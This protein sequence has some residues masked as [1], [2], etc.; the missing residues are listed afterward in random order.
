MHSHWLRLNDNQ[1]RKDFLLDEEFY[2]LGRYRS[3]SIRIHSEFASRHHAILK[4]SY[5][6]Q[7]NDYYYEIEDGDGK[8]KRSANGLFINDQK[9]YNHHLKDGDKIFFGP[10][11]FAIYYC[12]DPDVNTD[13]NPPPDGQTKELE[14]D[15]TAE[16]EDNYSS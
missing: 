6:E 14:Y 7:Q 10:K 4:R 12:C 1:G 11:I 3:S 9:K 2:S 16:C 8:G 13:I 15:T 5:D